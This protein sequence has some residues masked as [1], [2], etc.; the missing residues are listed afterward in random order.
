MGVK[1]K[2]DI[3]DIRERKWLQWYDHVKGMQEERL[4]K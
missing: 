1:K 4:P 3:I 2:P